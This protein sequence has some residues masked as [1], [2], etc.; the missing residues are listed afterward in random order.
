MSNYGMPVGTCNFNFS[1]LHRIER[2]R[3]DK[4]A[5]LRDHPD[6]TLAQVRQY[7][8]GEGELPEEVCQKIDA[9]QEYRKAGIEREMHYA[10]AQARY[11]GLAVPEKYVNGEMLDVYFSP[12][13][14]RYYDFWV[15]SFF[16]WYEPWE[17]AA[18]LT[19][20]LFSID[21]ITPE[22]EAGGGENG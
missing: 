18:L 12:E 22:R 9:M 16:S 19:G 15:Y 17:E 8:M 11:D 10:R 2:F 4:D 14:Y 5:L 21:S 6:I 20:P 3:K 7:L 1:T 13:T